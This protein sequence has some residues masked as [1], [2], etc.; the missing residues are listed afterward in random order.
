M[1]LDFDPSTQE[2]EADSLWVWEKPVLHR[3]LQANQ[4]HIA[5]DF[6]LEKKE[7]LETAETVCIIRFS[8][9]APAVT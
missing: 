2:A 6:V 4:G 5:Q 9:M 3:E 8:S 1:V 7:H